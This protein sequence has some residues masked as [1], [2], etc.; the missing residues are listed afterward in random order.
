MLKREGGGEVQADWQVRMI[1]GAY[2]I[3]DVKVEGHSLRSFT[4]AKFERVLR[5]KWI[6]GLITVLKDWVTSG[7]EKPVF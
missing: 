5:E 6:D 2:Q 7:I 1:N 3:V 4:R